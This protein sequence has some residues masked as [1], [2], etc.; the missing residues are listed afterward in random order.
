ME[1][2]TDLNTEVKFYWILMFKD[3][4]VEITAD[5]LWSQTKITELCLFLL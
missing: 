5:K 4:H 1:S 3:V 2:V